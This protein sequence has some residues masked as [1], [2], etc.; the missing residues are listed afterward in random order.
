MN[1]DK[2]FQIK[3]VKYLIWNILSRFTN[4]NK[5]TLN[6]RFKAAKLYYFIR[7]N[8]PWRK[9]DSRQTG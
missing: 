1:L 8:H 9:T 7:S 5:I 4:Y 6:S 3:Y 2:I